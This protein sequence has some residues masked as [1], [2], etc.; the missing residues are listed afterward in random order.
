[1]ALTHNY[2][3]SELLRIMK[4]I[5]LI[6]GAEEKETVK[7]EENGALSTHLSTLY[8]ELGICELH[9]NHRVDCRVDAKL[10]DH[11]NSDGSVRAS[12]VEVML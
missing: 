8:A 4:A 10:A 3:L 2:L 1:M 7:G 12:S 5:K 11:A 6:D 9:I